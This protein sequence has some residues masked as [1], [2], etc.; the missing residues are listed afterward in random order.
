[1]KK[2]SSLCLI[3]VCILWIS[4]CRRSSD[5]LYPF[6]WCR[7]DPEFD[8]L[9]MKLERLYYAYEPDSC[10]APVLDS[11]ARLIP[12]DHAPKDPRVARWHY[13]N[14]RL[15]LRRGEIDEAFDEFEHAIAITDSARHP[16]DVARIR[17][18]MEFDEPHTVD[19]YF[20]TL[21][22]I[23]FFE[24]VPDLTM[25]AAYYMTLGAMM[26]EKS[27]HE[28]ALVFFGKADS[29]LVISGLEDMARR[30]RINRS[31]LFERSGRVDEAVAILENLLADS[32]FRK[33]EI[34]VNT[35]LWNLY[36]FTGR[37][38]VLEQAY[39]MAGEGVDA[40]MPEMKV[41]YGANLMEEYAKRGR[42]D[43]ARELAR[44]VDADTA[45]FETDFYRY[46]YYNARAVMAEADGDY[47][48]AARMYAKA[49]EIS[50]KM[51]TENDQRE[52]NNLVVRRGIAEAEFKAEQKRNRRT[53]V[54]LVVIVV[55]SVVGSAVVIMY[56]RRLQRK[57]IEALNESLENERSRRHVL[58]LQIAMNETGAMVGEIE[59][60]ID[61]E[62]GLSPEFRR[63]MH[64]ALRAHKISEDMRQSFVDTFAQ[65]NPRFLAR[66]DARYP[67]L[68]PAERRLAVY[69]A[70]GLDIKHISRLMGV[71]PESVKQARWRLRGKMGI[72]GSLDAEIAA[73]ASE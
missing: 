22:K 48:L 17:W 70:L 40:A 42:L 34:A 7:I 15:K 24:S 65:T 21:E 41:L 9:S 32:L 71:R 49:R 44:R 68:T 51:E 38:D 55:V 61:S 36:T 66:L 29:L 57:S 4:G 16:Y 11:M 50:E 52:I 47:K 30:N 28:A 56:R 58:A 59:S 8:S 54:L 3:L 72:E 63:K 27:D 39:A 31:K 60:H 26:T 12:A 64:D 33:E 13:W 10:F 23:R 73:L 25:A 6:G 1:M 67:N 69:T 62:P 5:T 20:A 53:V 19:D 2:I 14:A 18:N 45:L 46:E 37:L 35:A 43:L